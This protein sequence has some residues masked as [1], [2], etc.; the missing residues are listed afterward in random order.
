MER[1]FTAGHNSVISDPI[2]LGFDLV[3]TAPLPFDSYGFP[4]PTIRQQFIAKMKSIF[5]CSNYDYKC[6]HIITKTAEEYN[7]F[8]SDYGV[9]LETGAETV[10]VF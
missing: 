6:F 9:F 3:T 5:Q 4:T 2:S 10:R 1:I 7:L 8:L